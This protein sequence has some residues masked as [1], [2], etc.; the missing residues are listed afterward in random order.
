MNTV[1]PIHIINHEK[2]HLIES[3]QRKEN[4]KKGLTQD[5]IDYEP[6]MKK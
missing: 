1:S 2:I 5:K 4:E 6:K 3:N